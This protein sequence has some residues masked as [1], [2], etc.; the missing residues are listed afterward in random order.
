MNRQ[1]WAE[2]LQ[3]KAIELLEFTLEMK[4][5]V[6]EESGWEWFYAMS[7]LAD[8]VSLAVRGDLKEVALD[9]K[10]KEKF[11]R[12]YTQLQQAYL[13]GK[14][15]GMNELTDKEKEKVHELVS[16]IRLVRR[17]M[18]TRRTNTFPDG[19]TPSEIEESTVPL[20][21]DDTTANKFDV[22]VAL[23]RKTFESDRKK[24]EIHLRDEL[25]QGRTFS[26]YRWDGDIEIKVRNDTDEQLVK[27][28]LSEIG[29]SPT[30]TQEQC[31]TCN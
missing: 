31:Q 2:E 17:N 28:V 6:G 11:G 9:S 29:F 10:R 27:S 12:I 13:F 3:E 5:E 22:M 26:V 21:V 14:Q 30:S 20:L 8:Q 16:A 1:K 15:G 7:L 24:V 25:P 18:P 23:P 19:A 4:D